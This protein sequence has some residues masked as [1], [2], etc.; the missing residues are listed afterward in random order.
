MQSACLTLIYYLA[1]ISTFLNLNGYWWV[2][3]VSL[4]HGTDIGRFYRG[5]EN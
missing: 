1:I 2:L 5:L 4:E 3:T